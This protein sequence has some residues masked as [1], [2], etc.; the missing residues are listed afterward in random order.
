MQNEL[1]LFEQSVDVVLVNCTVDFLK[2]V[3]SSIFALLGQT[4]HH[5]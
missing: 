2:E 3:G 5:V 1:S 4:T